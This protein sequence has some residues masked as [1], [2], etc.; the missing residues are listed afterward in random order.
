MEPGVIGR[1]SAFALTASL[2]GALCV[3]QLFALWRSPAAWSPAVI[4]VSITPG[5]S[6]TLGQH[7][8]A[9]PQA[10]A[11]HIALRRDT[12][13]RWF[14][15]NISGARQLVLQRDGTDRRTGTISLVQGQQFRL[16]AALFSVNA[17]D[18]RSVSFSEGGRHWRYDGATLRRDGSAQPACPD[19]R[20]S[21]RLA[22]YWNR[23]APHALTLARPLTFG[24]NL[25]CGNRL[26]IEYVGY[27][28][29]LLSRVKG[30]LLL[31]N[32]NGTPLSMSSAAGA[33][34]LAQREEP[35]DSVTALV[36]GRTR[37]ATRLQGNL[38]ELRPLSHVALFADARNVLPPHVQWEWRQRQAWALPGGPAWWIAL[39]LCGALSA[40][41][42]LAW[43]RGHWPFVRDAGA[44]I[45]AASFATALLAIAGAA[46]LIL[47]RS[48]TPPGIGWSILLAGAALWCCLLLPGRLTLVTAAGTLLLAVGLLAQLELGLG[49]MESSWL[50]HYQKTTA[51]LAIGLGIGAHLRLRLRGR[52][53]LMPQTRLEWMLALLAGCAL[54]ALLLQVLLGDETG[55]FDLQPVEF[56]KLALT[57]LT[58]HCIAIGLGWDAAMLDHT[59][60]AVRWF[61]LAAP[62]VLFVALLGL[63]LVQV[64]DYS[65]LIL[66]AVWSM[67][68]AFAYSIAAGRHAATASIV[69]LACLA[70]GAVAYL[71]SAGA[72]E[73]AQWSFYADRF[74]V[75]LDPASHPHTGQ[76]LLLGARA[77]AEGAWWGSDQ[78]LG[79]STM[80]Q[81]AGGALQIPAVQDDFAPSFFMNRHGLLGALALWALQALFLV[82]VLQTAVRSYAASRQARDF[83]QAWMGRFRC[84]ALCG[85]AAFVLGHFLLSWGT[86]LAIFPIMGQ[87]MSFLSAGGSHLLFFICP[88]LAFSA[89]SA[90]SLEEIQSCRSMS[91]TKC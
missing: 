81:A 72:G 51:L 15:R 76:Q 87:P 5:E 57:A 44:A 1:F 16:G 66:L 20:I 11:T 38:L 49:A 10:D 34:N 43:Q 52:G 82:G 33:Y 7:E 77:I 13:G 23:L 89:I 28:S 63:A 64:D 80:G 8:L 61:R 6:V 31:S 26:G 41:G 62:A 65:P 50:R 27:G 56:A 70:A 69:A 78:L 88:L 91:N 39:G 29:A 35:L 68:M 73:V 55:V 85:G 75:W 37:F 58:A 30:Q 22:A 67:A 48:A 71:R 42:A 24:G 74:L 84:F 53:G 60:P 14:A 19:A 3:L 90:Q 12:G 86:N 83:R 25:Y 36:A 18:A 4:A 2:L 40:A 79:L 21:S 46:A 9:A 32:S 47:Q 59:R 45:R 54:V 17:A